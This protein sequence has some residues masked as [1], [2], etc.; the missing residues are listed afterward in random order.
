MSILS[1]YV[2]PHPPLI[3]PEIGKGEEKEISK[4]I[5]SYRKVA[6]EIGR[7]KPETIILISPHSVMYEDYIHIAPGEKGFG[8]FERFGCP[9]VGVT[10][11]YDT[12]L[13]SLLQQEAEHR[14][15]PAG[16]LG[17]IDR[18][19][20]HGGLIPLYFVAPYLESYRLCRISVSGLTL[21][22]HYAFGMCIQSAVEKLGRRTV[23]IASG[24]LSHHL[25]DEGP[26]H[27]TPQGPAFDERITRDLQKAD[28]LDFLDFEEDFCRAAGECGMRGFAMMAGA[29]DQ[30]AVASDLLSYEGP[31]GV[32]YCVCKFQ[33][34]G[35][36]PSRNFLDR[37]R[38]KERQLR[39]QAREKADPYAKLAI[40]SLESYFFQKQ[41]LECPRDLP[42]EMTKQQAGV[43][44]SL[45]KD[46]RLRG[47]IGTIEPA[48]DSVAEE[49]IYNAVSAAI[50][51]SR[52]SPVTK[53][54]VPELDVS[55]DVLSLPEKV[56][57]MEE[58]DPQKFGVI[59]SCGNLRGLLLPDLE[60][61]TTPLKQLEI[62]R[63]KAG[64][65]AGADFTIER[66]EVVRHHWGKEKGE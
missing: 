54:E 56:D 57:S 62:A 49:I 50:G 13:V 66:F 52:F 25:K 12:Q 30:R 61:V 22:E 34:T 18:T 10:A 11:S 3:I 53:E 65:P 6:E 45:K 4:T 17:E 9:R 58:L 31:F 42:A 63:K 46:G 21:K 41:I 35:R 16:T 14:G 60:G 51:D 59:V 24:D 32:G 15:I 37:Y 1:A 28:F 36:D 47:C 38:E 43:F 19:I 23:V 29:L 27:Y 39:K 2:L 7:L 26:Y 5:D 55:V 33:V 64:I 20:D 48:S 8:T 40:Q 44:V